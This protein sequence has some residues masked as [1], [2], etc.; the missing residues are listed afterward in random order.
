V[1]LQALN[2]GVIGPCL[3]DL[4]A[5]IGLRSHGQLSAVFT[6]RGLLAI[7]ASVA[8]G[9]VLDRVNHYLLVSLA[10]HV[11][12]I[13][14]MAVSRCNS[15]TS[16]LVTLGPPEFVNCGIGMGQSVYIVVIRKS[17]CRPFSFY[18]A[19]QSARYLL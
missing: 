10:L 5:M 18:R 14:Y 12:F 11:D 13:M 1:V 3:L 6:V 4:E 17:I 16:L 7:C 19:T 2:L 8:L 9:P 15:F